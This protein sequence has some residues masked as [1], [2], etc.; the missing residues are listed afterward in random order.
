[1]NPLKLYIL[2][3]DLFETQ[4]RGQLNMFR[5]EY[6][7][8]QHGDE[9][10]LFYS[11]YE[12]LIYLKTEMNFSDDISNYN[13]DYS[14][15]PI[16]SKYSDAIRFLKRY[17][18]EGV[19]FHTK[20]VIPENRFIK[21]E[22]EYLLH[23]IG[24]KRYEVIV[25]NGLEN[26]Q[27]LF[28]RHYE[29]TLV[30]NKTL[31]GMI[32]YPL[33]LKNLNQLLSYFFIRTTVDKKFNLNSVLAYNFYQK[34]KM[35]SKYIKRLVLSDG[36][37][38]LAYKI[39]N[40]IL[41]QDSHKTLFTI[42]NWKDR[43]IKSMQ[44]GGELIEG[45][46]VAIDGDVYITEDHLY[47]LIVC[48]SL[49]SEVSPIELFEGLEDLLPQYTIKKIVEDNEYPLNERGG[50]E[51]MKDYSINFPNLDDYLT[52]ASFKL[53]FVDYNDKEKIKEIIISEIN[54]IYQVMKNKYE[55]K[56]T[57][58]T[59]CPECMNGYVWQARTNYFCNNCSFIL[60]NKTIIKNANMLLNRHHLKRL[61]ENDRFEIKI[62][63]QKYKL[64]NYNM[65][66]SDLLSWKII[67]KS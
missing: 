45:G 16:T 1:M 19:H 17:L 10:F 47:D 36:T 29:G 4:M 44:D 7:L 61:I 13:I 37:E 48:T 52:N 38:M 31:N 40:P 27:A 46:F 41:I 22:V 9:Y 18:L 23:Y 21:V 15:P 25:E 58:I 62:R 50:I 30:E 51:Y 2:P 39:T 35:V 65:R 67:R 6:N 5:R 43:Y 24:I 63:N 64:V 33:M 42:H 3:Y 28:F 59:V 20:I 12:S 14:L 34:Q 49:N 56:G 55:Y 60:W 66:N 54:E 53:Q 8:Y 26:K 57:P 11:C 32:Y